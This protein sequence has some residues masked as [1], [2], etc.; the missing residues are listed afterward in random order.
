MD[1]SDGPRDGLAESET[2][3]VAAARASTRAS[4]NRVL[5]IGVIL[6]QRFQGVPGDSRF[7]GVPRVGAS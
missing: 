6:D 5:C 3:V 1:V 7:Q 4:F 2:E